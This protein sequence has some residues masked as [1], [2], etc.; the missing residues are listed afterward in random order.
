M[1]NFEIDKRETPPPSRL[2]LFLIFYVTILSFL[3]VRFGIQFE[4]LKKEMIQKAPATL[5]SIIEHLHSLPWLPTLYIASLKD[6][7]NCRN[8]P[9]GGFQLGEQQHKCWCLVEN[10][11]I[12]ISGAYHKKE[13]LRPFSWNKI[14]GFSVDHFKLNGLQ[15]PFV[16]M[17]P[18]C[19]FSNGSIG[20]K[21]R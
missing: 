7:I 14:I 21:R 8:L 12:G 18:N 4:Q 17:G 6:S 5:P 2:W 9:H 11:T 15:L 10:L 16:R 19:P 1:R 3:K 20:K 13:N